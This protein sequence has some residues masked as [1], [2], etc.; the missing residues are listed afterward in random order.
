M[1]RT[2]TTIA[3]LLVATIATGAVV[4]AIAQNTASN[5]RP[6]AQQQRGGDGDGYRM[7]RD[8]QGNRM[9]M[10]RGGAGQILGMVCSEK[11]AD[12][13]QHML[14]NIEQRTDPTADQ[15]ALFDTF[16]AS[17]IQAQTDFAAACATARPDPEQA[18]ATDLVDQIGAR[19]EIQQAHLDAMSAVL[20]DFE[21]FYD[22]LSDEQKQAMQ[23]HRNADKAGQRGGKHDGQ[24]DGKRGEHRRGMNAPAAP[25][26]QG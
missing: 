24:R 21:A 6:Q 25:A 16:E 3:A 22:S 13:L 19:L 1:K 20:P 23:P 9:Q 8:G 26:D 4:P 18:E 17:A 11:G 12:R 15:Q 5:D 10:R 7:R 14:L 2:T